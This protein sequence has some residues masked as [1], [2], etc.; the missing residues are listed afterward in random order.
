MSSMFLTCGMKEEMGKKTRSRNHSNNF[1]FEAYNQNR[2]SETLPCRWEEMSEIK[3]LN[4]SGVPVLN[5]P[6]E[7]SDD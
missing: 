7:N 4:S 6:T 5:Q 3:L 2:N 1:D